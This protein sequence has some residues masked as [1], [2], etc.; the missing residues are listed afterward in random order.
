MR[1]VIFMMGMA[2]C[3][4]AAASK[5]SDCQAVGVGMEHTARAREF[6]M[7]EEKMLTV[8]DLSPDERKAMT[9]E[10]YRYHQRISR[11]AQKEIRYVYATKQDSKTA[12]KEGYRKCMAGDFK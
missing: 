8:T 5:E 12:R 11:E 3:G 1:T 6:G 2:V 10:Q 4:M 9:A 7:S